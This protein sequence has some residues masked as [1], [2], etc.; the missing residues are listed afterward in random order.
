MNALGDRGRA[1]LEVR[2]AS[3]RS[4][5]GLRGA[6]CVVLARLEGRAAHGHVDMMEEGGRRPGRERAHRERMIE[7]REG[8][9]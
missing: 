5:G 8:K 7:D 9:L 4:S 6:L 3:L 1:V 2:K